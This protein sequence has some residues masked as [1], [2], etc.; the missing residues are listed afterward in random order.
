M[1]IEP[2][3]VDQAARLRALEVLAEQHR[4]IRRLAVSLS[5]VQR[6]IRTAANELEWRSSSRREFD[7]RMAELGDG[8]V[9][10]SLNLDD[11]LE[12]CERARAAVLAG[13]PSGDS[14]RSGP[15]VQPGFPALTRPTPTIPVFTLSR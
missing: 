2:G 15:V 11:A 13:F 7:E 6:R 9:R 12:Q 8:L 10:V 14:V 5:P 1:D 3:I 4:H